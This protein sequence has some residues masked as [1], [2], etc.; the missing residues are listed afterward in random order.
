MG[1]AAYWKRQASQD[2][3]SRQF[4]DYIRGVQ[5]WQ[6]PYQSNP[7]QLPSNYQHV[8]A[9]PSGGFILSNNPNFNPNEGSTQNWTRL[10][11]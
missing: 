4:S 7:V 2:R 6:S 10:E 9:S 3:L 1:T 8:W 11:K 5:S